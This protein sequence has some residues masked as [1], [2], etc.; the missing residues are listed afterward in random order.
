MAVAITFIGVWDDLDLD[1]QPKNA[2][3]AMDPTTHQ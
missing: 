3:V 1:P 2:H